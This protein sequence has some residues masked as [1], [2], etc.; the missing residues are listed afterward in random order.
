[1]EFKHSAQATETK[2]RQESETFEQMV[3]HFK[4]LFDALKN[5]NKNKIRGGLI[6]LLLRKLEEVPR[7]A[8]LIGVN[9][10][11]I[12]AFRAETIEKNK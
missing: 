6:V 1:M 12:K 4:F 11:D 2:A 10:D 3:A 8:E 5:K 7:L 9:Q